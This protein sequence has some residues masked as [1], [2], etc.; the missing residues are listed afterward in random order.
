M[1]TLR[2]YAHE[3]SLIL[4]LPQ[5]S[6]STY[7]DCFKGVDGRRTFC[8]V[9]P[10]LTQNM[11]G[12]NLA[13]TYCSLFFSLAGQKDPLVS[14]VITTAVGL[15]CNFLSF[16]ILESKRIGRWFLLFVGLVVMTLCMLGIALI[17]VIA[18]NNGNYNGAAGKMLTF[19]V[20]LFIAGSTLGPGV[21]GWTYT[22]KSDRCSFTKYPSFGSQR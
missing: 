22:G 5:A 20:A 15:A 2:Y 12:Q 19:F 4:A 11:S 17:D 13:G 14:S 18:N 21:A 7:L 8:A 10:A 16:F 6:G 3:M 1:V 9:F